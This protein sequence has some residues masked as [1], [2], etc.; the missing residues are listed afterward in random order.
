MFLLKK[1][2]ID[3]FRRDNVMSQSKTNP[4]YHLLNKL[5]SL[6]KIAHLVLLLFY[7]FRD[8]KYCYQVFHHCIKSQDVVNINK[9]KFEPYGDLLDQ[10]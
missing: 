3:D 5:L 9:M 10:A 1:D 8:K 4:K 6:E 2:Q 7:P